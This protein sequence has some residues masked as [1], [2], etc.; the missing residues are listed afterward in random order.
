M[1]ISKKIIL[2]YLLILIHISALSAP[3]GAGILPYTY[4]DKNLI[5]LIGLD[6][7]RQNEGGWTD[8]G[9]TQEDGETDLITAVR[10]GT[11]ETAGVIKDLAERTQE[12]LT[13]GYVFKNDGYC[14]IIVK[15]PYIEAKVFQCARD[16]SQNPTVRE[17]IGFAWV[18]WTALVGPR[19]VPDDAIV[20]SSIKEKIILYPFFVRTL[21]GKDVH[22]RL[23]KALC[24]MLITTMSERKAGTDFV[25]QQ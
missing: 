6:A 21:S 8:F 13:K 10:E 1:L 20:D 3:R 11:E 14:E 24:S 17:K 2:A 23:F 19:I 25:A 15:I 12:S 16:A 5:F 18:K 9:G 4:K 7:H 22:G